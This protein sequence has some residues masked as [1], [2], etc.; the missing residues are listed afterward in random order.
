MS[1]WLL[2]R[3]A[4]L[5]YAWAYALLFASCICSSESSISAVLLFDLVGTA[6]NITLPIHISSLKPAEQ[7]FSEGNFNPVI[8]ICHNKILM[9]ISIFRVRMESSSFVFLLGDANCQEEN[10]QHQLAVLKMNSSVTINLTDSISR[11][12]RTTLRPLPTDPVERLR[13]WLISGRR[14]R[15]QLFWKPSTLNATRQSSLP[16]FLS[17]GRTGES[18]SLVHTTSSRLSLVMVHVLF[19]FLA[20]FVLTGIIGLLGYFGQR[21]R[22]AHRRQKRSRRLVVATQKALKTLTL[23]VL[24]STDKEVSSGCDQCA[25]CIE[26][27][28]VSEV[29]RILPCRHVFHK[30]CIDPWLLEQRSCPLCKLDIFKSC[31]IVLEHL[32]PCDDVRSFRTDSVYEQS[33]SSSSS[34][35]YQPTGPSFSWMKHLLAVVNGPCNRSVQ[36]CNPSQYL[37]RP[38]PHFQTSFGSPVPRLRF[39][40]HDMSLVECCTNRGFFAACGGPK[41]RPSEV[42]S[43]VFTS[44]QSFP[45]ESS[46]SECIPFSWLYFC[47]CCFSRLADETSRHNSALCLGCYS[48]SSSQSGF[49]VQD[50]LCHYHASVLGVSCLP[51]LI[52][53]AHWRCYESHKKAMESHLTDFQ[54]HRVATM[55][56][57]TT[58]KSHYRRE[59]WFSWHYPC[60]LMRKAKA[61]VTGRP[62]AYSE[63]EN[64]GVFKNL[65]KT[66][67]K[68]DFFTPEPNQCKCQSSE[69][70]S[71]NSSDQA[72][73]HVVVHRHEDDSPSSMNVQC[74]AQTSLKR[75][76]N[77]T[78]PIHTLSAWTSDDKQH[79]LFTSEQRLP[80]LPPVSI[81]TANSASSSDGSSEPSLIVLPPFVAP[82]AHA[83]TSVLD[84]FRRLAADP[85]PRST[86]FLDQPLAPVNSTCSVRFKQSRLPFRPYLPNGTEHGRTSILYS[87]RD[88]HER[89]RKQRIRKALIP[90]QWSSKVQSNCKSTDFLGM[91]HPRWRVPKSQSI[92]LGT[93]KM[94]DEIPSSQNSPSLCCHRTVSNKRCSAASYVNPSSI[95]H[96]NEYYSHF[97]PM[98][99][100]EQARVRTAGYGVCRSVFQ[101][102]RDPPDRAVRLVRE[103]SLGSRHQKRELSSAVSSI[104]IDP[105][106][107][108][109]QVH[110]IVGFGQIGGSDSSDVGSEAISKTKLCGVRVTI[111][112]PEVQY[113]RDPHTSDSSSPSPAN[114]SASNRS[115]RHDTT[116]HDEAFIIPLVDVANG[117]TAVV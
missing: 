15:V 87:I 4:D 94:S 89:A 75:S 98:C 25:V 101:H 90:S 110:H 68:S 83:A 82:R 2:L 49:N 79:I 31:G 19:T 66:N 17:A 36:T 18:T 78:D 71:S 70:S 50:R 88:A 46:N 23:R 42:T 11:L 106:E 29:V 37:A 33:S 14:V 34:D 47:C 76:D 91:L 43:P 116:D 104:P 65:P 81:T 100:V 63:A 3:C 41:Q 115:S 69:R 57:Q 95:A 22:R 74:S 6:E 54:T 44:A 48:R 105:Y 59:R 51:N 21:L 12:S 39:D 64:S 96:S 72:E 108:H 92:R 86:C 10:V 93:V 85:M 16:V 97:C 111:E 77:S 7:M 73:Q 45:L 40:R 55:S 99:R 103:S 53:L 27:Y 84:S 112:P 102:P 62:R 32:R 80:A 61:Y 28:R 35:N 52:Q 56:V 60:L 113:H 8:F 1:C 13:H 5:V 109:S 114:T 38:F 107:V 58:E 24:Q 30:K 67:D 9:N 20:L 26:L 117:P